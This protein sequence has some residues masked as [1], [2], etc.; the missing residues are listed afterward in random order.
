MFWYNSRT[1]EAQIL[2]NRDASVSDT[3][4]IPILHTYTQGIGINYFNFLK[5]YY[6][7][8]IRY[9]T[10]TQEYLQDT[11]HILPPSR[12]ISKKNSFSLSQNISKKDKLLFYL[13]LFKKKNHEIYFKENTKNYDTNSYAFVFLISV[14]FVFLLVIWD[15]R[16]T[17]LRKRWRVK[18][19]QCC[20][21]SIEMYIIQF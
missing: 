7:I 12:N 16:S 18:V 3:Y 2:Q 14:F 6:R 9:S 1:Y 5:I 20:K 8:L 19:R 4:Q 10:D 11:S 21:N 17:Y 15:R 13:I